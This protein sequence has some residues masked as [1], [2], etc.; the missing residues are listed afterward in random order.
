MH[1]YIVKSVAAFAQETI[2]TIN[3]NKKII[4][5]KIASAFINKKIGLRLK[6]RWLVLGSEQQP[7]FFLGSLA[8]MQA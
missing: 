4:F 2:K 6:C 8:I 7:M 1:D 3:F 5:I